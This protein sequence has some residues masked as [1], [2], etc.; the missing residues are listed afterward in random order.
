MS[1]FSILPKGKSKSLPLTV[2]RSSLNVVPDLDLSITDLN[3][4]NGTRFK[5]FFNNGSGGITFTVEVIINEDDVYGNTSVLNVLDNIYTNTEVVSVV[6]EA[7]DIP[8][9]EYIIT[10]NPKRK[11]TYKGSTNW[12]LEFTTY[13]PLTIWKYKNDNTLIKKAIK[14]A[15]AKKSVKSSSTVYAKL[16]KCKRST[17]VYSKKQKTVT[18]VKYMQKV[19]YK[20]GFLSKNQV[21]GWF[22]PKTKA[23]VKK[24]QKKFNKTHVKTITVKS[25]DA[26]SSNP[27]N[28]SY[29]LPTNGKVDATT[30]K[31]LYGGIK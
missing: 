8:N 13:N 31:A 24:F 7:L 6:T 23:A 18:C 10:K 9:G 26:I 29:K 11:Q 28:L 4:K 5:Q 27:N 20:K 12:E 17:L 14:K 3:N 16:K 15:N 21:D 25:G 30:F 1:F 19:L 2:I 22:G